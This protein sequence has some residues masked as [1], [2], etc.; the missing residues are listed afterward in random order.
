[1]NIMKWLL[2]FFFLT[3]LYQIACL[4]AD[5]PLTMKIVDFKSRYSLR[6]SVTVE[7]TN[8]TSEVVTFNIGI[9]TRMDSG[10][11]TEFLTNINDHQLTKPDFMLRKLPPNKS[12][13]LTWNPKD[14]TEHNPYDERVFRFYLAYADNAGRFESE[15]SHNI[16]SGVGK[17]N[18]QLVFSDIFEVHP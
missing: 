13:I 12:Q 16:G 9:V 14:V 18:Q 4:A 6:D 17:Q 2:S 11:W 10:Q 15:I 3:A 8:H 7:V 1:M 5:R